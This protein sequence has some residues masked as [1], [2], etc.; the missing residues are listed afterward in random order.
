MAGRVIVKGSFTNVSASA[1]FIAAL[2]A[3]IASSPLA[4]DEGRYYAV[5]GG[6][7]LSQPVQGTF[8][9]AT[10]T[11]TVAVVPVEGVIYRISAP[12]FMPDCFV[13]S[14]AFLP[15]P[16]NADVEVDA[17]TLIGPPGGD[18]LVEYVTLTT[19]IASIDSKVATAVDEYFVAH[20]PAGGGGVTDH[21][22][23]TGLDNDDHLIYL[24]LLYTSDAADE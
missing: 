10:L 18:T 4:D 6:E 15:M 16:A 23:L 14:T 8:D 13:D 1:R 24:C 9:A 3:S 2:T 11:W 22:A 20:P 21:G 7:I 12:G 19:V 17:D 5:A